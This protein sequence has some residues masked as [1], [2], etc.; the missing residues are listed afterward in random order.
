M[1]KLNK[2]LLIAICVMTSFTAWSNNMADSLQIKVDKRNK[3]IVP[4]KGLLVKGFSLK[5]DLQEVFKAKGMTLDDATWLSI[6]EIVNADNPKDTVLNFTNN[7]QSVQ[8]AFQ[9]VN[10]VTEEYEGANNDS[11]NTTKNGQKGQDG[12]S[13]IHIKDGDDEVHITKDGITVKDGNKDYVDIDFND[14]NDST[15]IQK[16]AEKAFRAMGGF[17]MQ[18]GLN[19]YTG[20]FAPQ[21]S[22]DYE[23]KTGGSRYFSFGWNKNG[24]LINGKNAKLKLNVGFEFSWYNFMLANDQLVFTKGT[25][26]VQLVTSTKDLKKSKL[27]AS[28]LTIPIIPYLSFK[29]GVLLSILGLGLT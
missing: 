27:T 5:N 22:A 21:N 11:K 26:N 1:K 20:N 15:Q 12:K 17:N 13:G 7:G 8:I 14:D 18:I 10:K 28:Y 24:T 3:S 29:K 9:N 19:G 16:A 6:K 25:N 2:I 4:Q 23:L